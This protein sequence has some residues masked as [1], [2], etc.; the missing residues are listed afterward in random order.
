[1]KPGRGL[2]FQSRGQGGVVMRRKQQGY[3]GVIQQEVDAQ[4]SYGLCALFSLA[5]L[6][7]LLRFCL[8]D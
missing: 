5:S 4:A 3:V 7:F 1:M 8:C 2:V 6:G